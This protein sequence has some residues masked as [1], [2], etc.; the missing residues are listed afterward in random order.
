MPPEKKRVNYHGLVLNR[1]EME[2]LRDQPIG[3][4]LRFEE[5]G[6]NFIAQ[7]RLP[8]CGLYVPKEGEPGQE[9]SIRVNMNYLAKGMVRAV[10]DKNGNIDANKLSKL[11]DMTYEF[12]MGSIP[13]DQREEKVRNF[14]DA[15]AIPEDKRADFKLFLK[16]NGI[17]DG[18]NS[19]L[20][21]GGI[22]PIDMMS[23][24][25]LGDLLKYQHAASGA[26]G[27]EAK[28]YAQQYRR[29]YENTL[30]SYQE[31]ANMDPERE[32]RVLFPMDCKS[33]AALMEDFV[34]Q[35]NLYRAAKGKDPV[36]FTNHNVSFADQ[37]AEA[38]KNGKTL[39]FTSHSYLTAEVTLPGAD[40]LAA[41]P[42]VL[43]LENTAPPAGDLLHR[44]SVIRTGLGLFKSE[45][46]I[47][48]YHQGRNLL[49]VPDLKTAV[50]IKHANV[51][52]RGGTYPT[53]VMPPRVTCSRYYE[54]HT[55]GA[56]SSIPDEKLPEY[57][58]KAAA[59]LFLR[60]RPGKFDVSTAR[61][62][63]KK[64]MDSPDFKAMITTK[65]PRQLREVLS[66]G[67]PTALARMVAADYSERYAVDEKTKTAFA[68]MAA[69]MNAEG[70]S[71]KFKA[72]KA[73]LGDPD[74]K[75]TGRVFDAIEG[76]LKGKKSM[77]RTPREK[78][79]VDLCL[80]ALGM[81]AGAGNAVAEKRAK[82]LVDRINEVRGT[83]PGD[84]NYVDL[85]ALIGRNKP[86]QA[87]QDSLKNIQI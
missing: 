87:D 66:T 4:I 56:I 64:L 40:G 42:F 24:E 62:Y 9:Y 15:L 46:E 17:P 80:R 63:A 38:K 32:T 72:L 30:R 22:G 14:M 53:L 39:G 78:E 11:T 34:N 55:G 49:D 57:A 44:P 67:D 21:N 25:I 43:T 86:L 1:N 60:N 3:E 82:I 45:K 58:A 51:S 35:A 12:Y 77:R 31:M 8:E 50:K 20:A 81:A 59:A 13:P 52:R 19:K 36:V 23:Q 71:E 18:E 7:A 33:Y 54:L 37:S 65:E 10:M 79:T 84:E 48:D 28:T 6:N 26:L 68:D 76:Y 41:E 61:K 75:D 73:A 5:R 74:M 83:R 2:A 85:K 16:A 70:R 69:A 29:Q 27:P 47:E